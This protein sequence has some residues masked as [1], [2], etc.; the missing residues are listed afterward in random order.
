MQQINGKWYAIETWSIDD[1]IEYDEGLNDLTEDEAVTVLKWC[2][3]YHDCEKGMSWD[4]V[5]WA[6]DRVVGAREENAA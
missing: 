4:L 6:I 1:V 3:K 5:G 2:C